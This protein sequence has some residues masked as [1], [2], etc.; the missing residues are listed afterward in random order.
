MWNPFD[1]L[2]KK[3]IVTVNLSSEDLKGNEKLQALLNEIA[4]LKGKEAR[5]IAEE[6]KKRE[7]DKDKDEEQETIKYLNEQSKELN[8][9][10]ARPFS[11]KK[12]L[13][14]A[15]K[16]KGKIRYTTFN[17]SKDLGPVDD[18]VILPDGGFGV[19]SNKRVLF[20]S[21]DINHV[22]YW[23]AGLNNFAKKKII[24]LCLNNDGQFVPNIMTE[25][26]EEMAILRTDDKFKVS[27][28]SKLPISEYIAELQ[29][30]RS[31]LYGELKAQDASII[32]Q[33]KEIKEKDREASLHR[34][35]ADRSDSELS[36]SL[37]KISE[38]EKANGELIRQVS[39]LIQLKEINEGLIDSMESVVGNM[40]KKIEK[41]LGADASYNEWVD[42][43]DKLEWAK[44]N[45]PQT[46]YVNPEK[47]EKPT[48]SEQVRPVKA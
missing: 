2:F 30:E 36:M 1:F 24:P 40:D 46:I 35:R 29:D 7:S 20:G 32:E 4:Y 47:E 25:E 22:F 9:K 15:E 34:T 33:Q 8:K 41:H 43:K 14:F 12:F 38:I 23:T 18:F 11:I 26:T 6:G 39:T 37:H 48:L 21:G 19:V 44:R 45:M 17:G 42:L 3:K 13:K 10:E 31:G 28:F 27:R 16:N 5:R